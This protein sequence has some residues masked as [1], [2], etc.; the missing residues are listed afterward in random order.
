MAHQLQSQMTQP[1]C[2]FRFRVELCHKACAPSSSHL[3]GTVIRLLFDVVVT[4]ELASHSGMFLF[5]I[6]SFTNLNFPE[7][8]KKEEKRDEEEEEKENAL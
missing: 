3:I 1:V 8:E 6:F 2:C 5:F 7:E 4:T